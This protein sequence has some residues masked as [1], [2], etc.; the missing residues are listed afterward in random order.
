MELSGNL[1]CGKCSSSF[2]K[3][4]GFIAHT[5]RAPCNIDPDKVA[6]ISKDTDVQLKRF[7]CDYCKK[8]FTDNFSLKRHLAV[9]SGVKNYKCVVCD[10]AAKDKSTLKRHIQRHNGVRP[11]KCE[12]CG[13][14]FFERS[15]L[16]RHLQTHGIL[17]PG[18]PPQDKPREIASHVTD[19]GDITFP[20]DKCDKTYTS[21]SSLLQHRQCKHREGTYYECGIC[22]IPFHSSTT[23]KIHHRIHTGEKPFQC[24]QCGKTFAQ[25]SNFNKHMRNI[26][27]G[28]PIKT[29]SKEPKNEAKGQTSYI[30]E[31]EAHKS[32]PKLVPET[33]PED[34]DSEDGEEDTS[35]VND[36][37]ALSAENNKPEE[38]KEEHSVASVAFMKQVLKGKRKN[39]VK[40]K[41]KRPF[42]CGLCDKS[43]TEQD[44][45]M[46]HMMTHTGQKPYKCEYCSSRFTT[47]Y[48]CMKH[49]RVHTGEK[50]YHCKQCGK[51]FARKENFTVHQKLHDS[52]MEHVCRICNKAFAVKAYLK[53]HLRRHSAV[54]KYK[55]D[56]C[57]KAFTTSLSLKWH[58]EK[59]IS[60]KPVALSS[61]QPKVVVLRTHSGDVV[62]ETRL[63]LLNQNED[64]VT[65]GTVQQGENSDDELFKCDY[66][67]KTFRQKLTL[68]RHTL[69]HTDGEMPY[70]CEKCDKAYTNKTSLL[71][72][73]R[74]K[75]PERSKYACDRCGETF[76][77]KPTLENHN[78]THTGE[79]PFECTECGK[80]FAQK[81]N[82]NSH[83]K[84]HHEGRIQ[85]NSEPNIG[86][87]HSGLPMLLKIL[88][89]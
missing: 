17:M 88:E 30:S 77:S 53:V 76:G 61:S 37:S 2:S 60:L 50:P 81:S 41:V 56:Q 16:K 35:L 43:F 29:E 39:T 19:G 32:I 66:C 42:R 9:H 40:Q 21:K 86:K 44:N 26:H 68:E 74:C 58:K 1:T 4:E 33:S 12:I 79:R 10:Y 80:T 51:A 65:F 82:L 78:R 67:H 49:V 47:R 46:K 23:L 6:N 8:G 24:T 62:T 63:K 5:K 7:Q 73:K 85:T 27:F 3:L 11:H 22:G 89:K 20:C 69:S 34:D 38:T 54:K 48:D 18:M 28:R 64:S 13:L 87:K 31:K 59:H 57:N 14:A 36:E 72:H 75:H 25:R 84:V 15:K 71:Q 55:C 83:V 70:Q 52:K 45:L